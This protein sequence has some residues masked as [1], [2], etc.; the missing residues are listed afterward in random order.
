MTSRKRDNM[1]ERAMGRVCADRRGVG[2][3]QRARVGRLMVRVLGVGCESWRDCQN[4][5]ASRPKNPLAARDVTHPHARFLQHRRDTTREV[6]RSELLRMCEVFFRSSSRKMEE[7]VNVKEMLCCRVSWLAG[8]CDRPTPHRPVRACRSNRG[9]CG[10]VPRHLPWHAKLPQP[11][12][13]CC[14]VAVFITYR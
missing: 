4:E 6:R 5:E 11:A 10:K 14:I 12:L 13:P 8:C 9:A 1:C 3:E 7:K 2:D